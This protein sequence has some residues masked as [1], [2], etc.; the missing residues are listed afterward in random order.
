MSPPPT[1][2]RDPLDTL[3]DI[4]VDDLLDAAGLTWLRDTPLRQLFRAPAVRFASA[5]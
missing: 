5:A 4:N 1:A 3:T 2:S